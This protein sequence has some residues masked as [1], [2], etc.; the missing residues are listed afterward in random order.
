MYLTVFKDVIKDISNSNLT[1]MSSLHVPFQNI[2]IFLFLAICYSCSEEASSEIPLAPIDIVNPEPADPEPTDPENTA[3]IAI[4]TA[5][6]LNG[7]APLTVSFIGSDS[8]DDN[9]IASYQWRFPDATSSASNATYTFNTPG[10]YDITLTVT[11]AAGL[12][13]SSMLSIAV[14]QAEVGNI[15]C[16]TNGGLAGDTGLKSWCWEDI[17]LPEYLGSKGVAFSNGALNI[18]SECYEKQVSKAGAQLK[19]RVNPTSPAVESWCGRAYNMRA[20]I[21][22]TPW[23]I[24]HAKGTEEWF[25]W[26]YTFGTDYVIDKNSQWLFFQVH[27][28]ITGVSPHTEL[29]IIKDGQFNG[30]DAGELYI[31]NAGDAQKYHPTGITPTAGEK[32]KIVVHAIWGDASNGLLQVWING[33]KL[34]DKQVA[35]VYDAYPWGGNAKWGIYKWPWANESSVQ[36][37]LEQGVTHLETYMGSLRMITRRIGD[38]DYGKNSY[39]LVVPD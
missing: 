22:T 32:L 19:F 12:E 24:R 29:M 25:G 14:T 31:V 5:S 27:P 26:S 30:H 33:Q 20:E 7:D 3:P 1:I 15:P 6:T 23:N 36:K 18:D 34:Y 2:A 17:T 38:D 21:R 28:G 8:S 9:S 39:S 4:A 10:V 37:S 11:D 16:V 13:S 35:T